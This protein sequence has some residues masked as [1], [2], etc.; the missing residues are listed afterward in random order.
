MAEA[1]D[2]G[3]FAVKVPGLIERPRDMLSIPVVSTAGASVT[4]GL[5]QFGPLLFL[6][7]LMIVFTALK[8]S[9]IDPINAIALREELAGHFRD[10]AVDDVGLVTE[11]PGLWVA[12]ASG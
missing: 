4:L 2:S 7:I 10:L 6:I 9:F 11:Y 1:G 12:E 3:R 8:P 5:K